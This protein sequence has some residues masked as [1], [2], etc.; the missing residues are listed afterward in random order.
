LRVRRHV[1]RP[2]RQRLRHPLPGRDDHLVRPGLLL[3]ELRHLDAL[4]SAPSGPHLTGAGRSASSRLVHYI[5]CIPDGVTRPSHRRDHVET[6][7]PPGG[8]VHPFD[9]ISVDQLRAAGSTKWTMCPDAIGAFV[10][11]MDFGVP[12]QVADV[13]LRA[14][15]TGAMGYLPAA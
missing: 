4:T 12:P 15:D 6:D 2:H 1:R 8:R 11:E 10:A 7:D 9:A 14:A 13:V 3:G 5:A